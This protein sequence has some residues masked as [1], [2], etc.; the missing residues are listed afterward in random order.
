MSCLLVDNNRKLYIIYYPPFVAGYLNGQRKRGRENLNGENRNIFML[1]STPQLW[2]SEF[3]VDM[4][5][6]IKKIDCVGK[7]VLKLLYT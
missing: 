7:E 6:T 2:T 5:I 4:M 1:L 3:T